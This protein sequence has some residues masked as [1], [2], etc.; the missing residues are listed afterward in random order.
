MLMFK[1]KHPSKYTY[2]KSD[3]AKNISKGNF[4]TRKSIFAE[5]KRKI[6]SSSPRVKALYSL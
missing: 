2:I 6:D 3:L 4:E 5:E 1:E